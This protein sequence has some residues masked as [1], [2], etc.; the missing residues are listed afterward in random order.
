MERPSICPKVGVVVLNWNNYETSHRCL[1]S[2]CAASYPRVAVYLVDNA[3]TDGSVPRLREEF[4][5]AEAHCIMNEENLGFAA[6]C[7][8]GIRTALADQC[9]YVLLLNNDA[10]ITDPT[11]LEEGIRFIKQHPRCGILGGKIL[12]WPETQRIWSTGGCT[13]FWGRET[14][15]GYREVDLGQFNEPTRR[16]FISGACMLIP[17]G[18]LWECGLLPEAYFFGRE[19]WEFSLRV[20]KA[21][22]ELWYDPNF[23]ICHEASNSHQVTDP[24]YVYNDALSKV[25]YRHRNTSSLNYSLWRS[26]YWTYLKFLFGPRYRMLRSRYLQDVPPAVIR[27]AQIEGLRDASHCEKITESMLFAFKSK[28]EAEHEVSCGDRES[29]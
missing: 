18:V 22:Y 15:V 23:C 21:G 16:G 1:S 3:S 5:G 26:A 9:E 8:R 27:E 29:H 17:S 19:D 10:I 7:N 12:F 13:T 2:L 25:L 20:R 14:Y 6:G 24:M 4:E 28:I 11:F